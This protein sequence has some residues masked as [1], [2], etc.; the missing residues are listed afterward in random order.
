MGMLNISEAKAKLSSVI[1]R[2]VSTGDECLIGKAGKPVAKIVRYEPS[3]KP[4]RLGFLKGK[5]RLAKDWEEWP[6][7]IAAGLGIKDE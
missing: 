7:D 2:V 5:I 3:R 6:A 1:E 4:R